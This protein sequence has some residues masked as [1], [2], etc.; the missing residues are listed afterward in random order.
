MTVCTDI[1]DDGRALLL[2]RTGVTAG[3]L[4]GFGL[5]AVVMASNASADDRQPGDESPVQGTTESVTGLLSPLTGTVELVLEPVTSVVDSGVGTLTP[6]VAPIVAVAEPVT[7]P[8]FQP[9][10]STV[11]PITGSAVTE[12]V[13]GR[14]P[15]LVDPPAELAPTTGPSDTVSADGSTPGTAPPQRV[16]QPAPPWGAT[17][18]LAAVSEAIQPPDSSYGDGRHA[19]ATSVRPAQVS[20]SGGPSGTPWVLVGPANAF[21]GGGGSAGGSGGSPGA[22]AAMSVPGHPPGHIDGAR[23]PPDSMGG[24]PWFGYDARDH[25]G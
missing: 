19:S 7:T 3:F 23:S 18:A 2:R 1:S 13:I 24:Q 16:P 11:T 9:V 20:G 10:I 15:E 17:A 8:V 22:D 21:L 5:L 14:P 6:V 4:F 25:P 12:S